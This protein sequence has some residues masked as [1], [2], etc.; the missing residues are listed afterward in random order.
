MS[1]F[2]LPELGEGLSEG[3]IVA[4]RVKE[5]DTIKADSTMVEVMTDKATVEVPAPRSGIVKKLYYQVGQLAKVGGPLIDIE[6][7]GAKEESKSSETPAAKTQNAPAPTPSAPASSQSAPAP[8]QREPQARTGSAME[9]ARVLASPAVR[10]MARE[11]SV[12]LANIRGSGERGR[13]LRNDLVATTPATTSATSSAVA[14]SNWAEGSKNLEERIP[15]IGI[16]RKI[17]D[18]LSESMFTAVHFT[19]FD[20]CDFTEV[21]KLRDEANAYADKN[22]MGVRLSFLPF[23]IK[24]SI[25]AMRKFPILNSSLDEERNEVVIKHYYHFGISVQTDNGLMVAVV[26][27]C[28]KKDIY[29]LAKEIKEVADRARS[30]KASLQDLTGSTI[31]I[32]NPGNI[33][34]LYATPVINFPEAVILGMFQIKKRPIVKEVDGEETIV[35]RP[36]MYTNITCDHRIVDGAIAAGYLKQFCEYIEN[37]AKIAFM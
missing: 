17:A 12:D 21:M 32:T 23:F 27:D 33:G 4:W 25:A 36:M 24:A 37:P 1:T 34:G 18:R 35:A 11:M 16:R 31:T 28:D 19:H 30:G 20:E 10:R 7:T 2:K 3:E 22:K 5:G 14:R 29:Q 15:F 8:A 6:E 26:R 13:I 9:T